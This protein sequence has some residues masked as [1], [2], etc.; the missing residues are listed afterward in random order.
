MVASLDWTSKLSIALPDLSEVLH[1]EVIEVVHLGCKA[2]S[3]DIAIKPPNLIEAS[4]WG[5]AYDV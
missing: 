4:L 1:A 3:D 2:Q 5:S